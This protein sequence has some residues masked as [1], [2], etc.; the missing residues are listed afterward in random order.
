[1]SSV[2]RV[3][4]MKYRYSLPFS[5]D[6]LSN[7]DPHG[8]KRLL[9]FVANLWFQTSANS[10]I[11]TRR[12]PLLFLALFLVSESPCSAWN[13]TYPTLK[14]DNVQKTKMAESQANIHL[15]NPYIIYKQH[16]IGPSDKI[17]NL[18]DVRY[19]HEWTVHPTIQP[20]NSHT[21]CYAS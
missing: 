16:L 18:I 3:Y 11:C 13:S 10:Q 14:T 7:T 19:I 17:P 8:I 4:F 6:K 15:N 5:H 1:M 21:R 2:Q 20:L 9:Q 12:V